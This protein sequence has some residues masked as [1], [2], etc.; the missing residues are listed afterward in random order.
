MVFKISLTNV[1]PKNAL[2]AKKSTECGEAACLG[3][4]VSKQV[5]G[6]LGRCAES[7]N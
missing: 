3:A 7:A 1:C 2:L 5:V 6:T 4:G